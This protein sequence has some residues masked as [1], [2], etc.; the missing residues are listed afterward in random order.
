VTAPTVDGTDAVGDDPVPDEGARSEEPVAPPPRFP[1]WPAPAAMALALVTRL[2]LLGYPKVLVF[3]EVYYAPDAVDTLQWAAEHGRAK[4]P[5][6]GKWLIA[7]G[8]RVFGFTPFGWRIASLLAGVVVVGL[9]AASVRRLTRRNE[10]AF[11]AGVL[12]AADGVM[13]T[14]G[15]LAML[16]VFVALFVMLAVWFLAVAWAAPPGRARLCRWASLGAA[17]S[18]GLGSSVKWSV[19]LLWPI[20]LG[21]LWVVDRRQ[22]PPGRRLRAAALTGVVVLLVPPA[23]YLATWA[24]REV[25]SSPV[26]V[27]SFVHDQQVVMRFHRDLRPDNRNAAPATS[28]LLMQRPTMLFDTDCVP[29]LHHSVVG[30][31]ERGPTS[32]EARIE[33]LTNPAVWIVCMASVLGLL[34]LVVV[35]R[36]GLALWLL[37]IAATQ[38]LPWIFNARESY[39][40][41]QASLIP[42]LLVGAGVVAARGRGRAW[43]VAAVVVMGSAV[44]LAVLFYPI[45]TGL[46]LTPRAALFRLWLRG[47]Q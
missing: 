41:Y 3:D 12:T 39:S 36:S 37:L 40:F 14:S 28:W 18:V 43:T 45:W 21:V 8:I 20:V 44:G 24:P 23:L 2:P 5:P 42:V 32:T 4:H 46:P 29:A 38:W 25:G 26:S 16:D 1:W 30:V 7:G 15:R 19:V 31:C 33:S 34:A 13:F 47:W 11:A 22:Q 10:V 6:L 17:A 27:S 9:V 35:R